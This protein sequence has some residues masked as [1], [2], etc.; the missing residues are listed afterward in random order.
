[1][2]VL[3]YIAQR[4]VE[5][6][7]IPRPT[8]TT[9]EVLVQTHACGICATD[10]KTY[11]R[12]HP[13]FPPGTVLG[14]EISG[15]IV[16]SQAAGWQPGDRVVVAPF[17]PCGE[18]RYCLRHQWTLCPDL[19][20]SY[21]DPGG[22]SEYVRVPQAI[23]QQGLLHLPDHVDFL[24]GS[25]VEPLACCYHGFEA[26]NVRSDDT[27]L[28]I[29]DGPMGLMQAMIA[30]SLGI[31]QIVMA[32][33]TPPRLTLGARYAHRVINVAEQ[34]LH[35]A[36]MAL[37]DGAGM[38]KVFV[39][40]GQVE[41]AEQAVPLVRRGGAINFFAGLPS[42]AR[43]TLDPNRLHYQ[44]IFVSGTFAFAPV[45]FARALQALASGQLNVTGLITRTV[46]LHEIEQAFQDN[47]QY[48]G[49]KSVVVFG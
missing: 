43:V 3:R 49:I 21:V 29:G 47:T 20:K 40:V 39:S 31:A 6:G 35:D 46:R 37:S 1:M 2:N 16:E 42:N 12:G 33:L 22:F 30:R 44:E 15:V 32:G 34:N 27:L 45:H 7:D 17:V 23:V 19:V 11:V 18:C 25:L 14:H 48:Q 36:V 9:G 28:I 5:V 41:V 13:L 8:I 24:T 26:L 10:V 38:D 4:Q